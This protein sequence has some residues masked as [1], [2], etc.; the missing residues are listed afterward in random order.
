MIFGPAYSVVFSR[1]NGFIMSVAQTGHVG[2]IL[3]S[4][5]QGLWEIVFQDGSRVNAATAPGFR[6]EVDRGSAAL[7]LSWSGPD[8]E[9]SIAVTG[10]D[11]G[12]DLASEITPRGKTILSF[13]LPARLRFDPALLKRFV[14]PLHGDQSVG[15][16]FRPAFFQ[17]R[18]QDA[19][20]SW[21]PQSVGSRGYE[22]LFGGPIDQRPDQDAPVGLRVPAEARKWLGSDLADRVERAQA[23]VN[24]P[25]PRAQVDQVLANSANGPFFSS[26]RLGTGRLWRIGGQVRDADRKLVTDMIGSVIARIPAGARTRIGLIA[27]RNGP[28]AGAWA[29]VEVAEWRESLG[30]AGRGAPLLRRRDQLGP[31]SST[32]WRS[33]T[34]WRS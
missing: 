13:A 23:V 12:I 18:P 15:A 10:R 28:A 30:A 6:Y 33:A 34:A 26:A 20:T 25:T 11:E 4:G 21:T 14:F 31:L 16:A 19:P 5:E 24:R 27:L 22:S 2:S 8:A 7:R 3:T 9:V 17:R 32:R 1:A 29:A